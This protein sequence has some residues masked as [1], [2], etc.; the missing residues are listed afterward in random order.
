MGL[1][2]KNYKLS[3]AEEKSSNKRH[4]KIGN[5]FLAVERAIMKDELINASNKA[6]IQLAKSLVV[7]SILY[8]LRELNS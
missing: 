3:S 4:E 2:T 8:F 7:S 6:R 1:T 5:L